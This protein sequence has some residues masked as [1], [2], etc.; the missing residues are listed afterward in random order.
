MA[1]DFAKVFYN[2]KAW[3]QCR[4]SYIRSVHG[5]CERCVKE[6][7]R[8]KDGTIPTG[9]IVHHKIHLNEMNINDPSITL[10]HNNL[11][12]LCL[13]CHNKHHNFNREKRTATRSGFKFNS[14]GELVYED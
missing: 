10:N 7:I 1:K 13:E 4:S 14:K 5:L 12:Y 11:E 2:S 6:G 9:D 8:K 3:K